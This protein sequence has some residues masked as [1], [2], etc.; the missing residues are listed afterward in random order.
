M[1][2][3]A[4]GLVEIVQYG[5]H[6]FAHPLQLAHQRHQFH[7]MM[8]IQPGRWL[9]EQHQRRILRQ[10]QRQKSPLPLAAGKGGQRLFRQRSDAGSL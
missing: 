10:Q 5:D 7:L 3:V 2:A 4:A 1:V 8:N 9:I 6:G